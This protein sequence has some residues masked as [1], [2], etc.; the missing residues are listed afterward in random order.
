MKAKDDRFQSW[1]LWVVLALTLLGTQFL[2]PLFSPPPVSY[3]DIREAISEGRAS[4]AWISPTTVRLKLKPTNSTAGRE[5]TA[6]RVDDP[7]LLDELQAHSVRVYGVD[8]SQWLGF[9]PWLLLPFALVLFTSLRGLNGLRTGAMTFGQSKAKIYAEQEVGQRFGDVAGVDEAKEELQEVIDF[10]RFPEK[11]AR[12]GGQLPKGVLL[13]G[14]PGTGKT[15]LARA[16]AGEARVPFFS[17]SGSEFVEMFVGV[18]AARVRDLFK[19]AK[20]RAPCII[21]IDELDALGKVRGVGLLSH[22]EREQTLN[23]LLVELDGFDPRTGVVLMAATNRPEILD[24]ALLRAGR[25]DRQVLVDRPDRSARLAILELHARK[26][27]L[28]EDANL[29]DLAGMTAGMVGADL[30]NLI[31]EAALLAVRRN[32]DKVG[33]A[34]L[35]E[36]LERVLA[37]LE[38]KSRVLSPKEKER[39][40]HHEV[41]HAL[42]SLALP[43]QSLVRKISII[44]RGIAALGYTVQTP[45]Q[46]R[47]LSTQSELEDQIAM[48][49]GGRVA[50]ELVF[51]DRSTGAEDDLTKATLIARS[52]VNAYGM[53]NLLGEAH[54]APSK[55]LFAGVPDAGQAEHSDRTGRLIDVEVQRILAEQHQRARE[56]LKA[57]LALIR[58]A[59][60]ALLAK[61]TLSG[62]EL[63]SM[64][65]SGP[66]RSAA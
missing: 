1:S 49:M 17:I 41:G 26:V 31:N 22:D 32:R 2:M 35:D 12:L 50:E 11:F 28:G 9:L 42:V 19:Q 61:E 30:A 66:A 29:G 13:V 58:T 57:R 45:K 43:G 39:V 37:G 40:A 5:V 65:S 21:F 52:M 18:G 7:K 20:Q 10:L 48:L 51:G 23:Q 25:F 53:S 33:R 64:A 34:E 60:T 8:R 56:I 63:A 24:P 27:L 54:C 6:T 16:V 55:A 36:A 62:E 15:L 4:D 44:P 47:F 59:A 3:S 14:P 46:D 38:K